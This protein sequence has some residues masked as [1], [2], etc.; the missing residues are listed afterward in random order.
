GR[1]RAESVTTAA[2]DETTSFTDSSILDLG[3]VMKASTAISGEIVLGDLLRTLME[4]VIENAGAQHGVLLLEQGGEL[5]IRA[6]GGADRAVELEAG[7]ALGDEE[8]D[9]AR[10][11]ATVVQFVAR[12]SDSVML[13]EPADEGSYR[14]DPYIA[15]VRPRSLLCLPLV[16]RGKLTGVLYLEHRET[17]GVF[18]AERIELLRLLSGQ[19]A[20]SIDKALL[21]ENLEET[22]R[23]RTADVVQEKENVELAL[24]RLEATQ[25]QLV[26]AEK[27]ASLGELTA[28]IAHEIKNPLNCVNNFAE[29]SA[30][31]CQELRELIQAG[32]TEL[33]HEEIDEILGDL[34]SNSSQIVRHG[35]R[36]NAIVRAMMQHATAGTGER[37]RVALNE[38][39]AEQLDLAY[40]GL[41]AQQEGRIEIELAREFDP[42]LGLVEI[43]PPEMARVFVN[44]LNNA[45]DAVREKAEGATAAHEPFSPRVEVRTRRRNGQ[46]EIRIR[47]NGS[48]VPEE[49]RSRIFEPFFT[50]KPTGQGNT[51]LG[52]SLSYDIVTRGHGGTLTLETPD[53]PDD[54][55]T[56]DT[57]FLLTLP[58]EGAETI[59]GGSAPSG[60]APGRS[61]PGEAGV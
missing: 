26:Q 59:A 8:A 9:S 29:I 45:F 51:G 56:G 61:A 2:G 3:S 5:R 13:D 31:L 43:A 57:T 39:L 30:E 21:L 35:Q 25:V 20:I 36:A 17:A 23:E 12:T 46:A 7:E 52:L 6:S 18:D 28:G 19:I 40:H 58:L 54:R 11:P 48:G 27:M 37:Q 49:V 41:R 16:D 55:E 53:T 1:R 38:M 33:S 24:T 60:A 22:V 4:I 14:R 50:T 47:D 44:L 42:E 34:A 15:E 32:T 10:V